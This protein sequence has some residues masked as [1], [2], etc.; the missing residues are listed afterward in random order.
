[1]WRLSWMVASA[2]TCDSR[3]STFRAL[4]GRCCSVASAFPPARQSGGLLVYSQIPAVDL[5]GYGKVQRER[6]LHAL[7]NAVPGGSQIFEGLQYLPTPLF[8]PQSQIVLVSPLLEDE[9]PDPYPAPS[10]AVSSAG[11]LPDPCHSRC[12]FCRASG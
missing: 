3:E 9:P 8:P 6:I 10:R 7:A 4:R 2:P 5:S 1:M 11:D 12:R